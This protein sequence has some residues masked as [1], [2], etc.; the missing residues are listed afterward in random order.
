M[1]SNQLESQACRICGS[2]SVSLF[3]AREMMFGLR[4]KFSYFECASC[5]CVQISEYPEDIARHYPSNYYAFASQVDSTRPGKLSR[6]KAVARSFAMSN[7]TIRTAWLQMLSNRIWIAKQPNLKFYVERFRDASARMLDVGCGT[8]ELLRKFRVVGFRNAEGADPYIE[9]DV[10]HQG[11]V[12]VWKRHLSEMTSGYNCISFHHSLEHMPDQAAV[13]AEARRLL[14]P[15]GIIVIRVPVAGTEA[16]RVYKENWVQLDPPRHFYLH[17]EAS[18]RLLAQQCGMI[19]EDIIYD[20]SG[21]QI[22]GSELYLKDIPLYDKRSPA[23]GS[24]AIFSQAELAEYDLR[25]ADL[26]AANNGDQVM[27]ILRAQP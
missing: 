21:L 26:N 12:L 13:I 25:A 24:H 5:K 6:L 20:S 23:C 17:S 4:E 27:A 1:S 16:W 3:Q 14:A 7:S 8:G 18:L 22:W 19:V 11:K 15:G 10:V 2:V 9:S